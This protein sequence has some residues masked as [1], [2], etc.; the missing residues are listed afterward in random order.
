MASTSSARKS[1]F[2]Y[3]TISTYTD[4]MSSRKVSVR[5]RLSLRALIQIV[6]IGL[7]IYLVLAGLG[8]LAKSISIMRSAT[9]PVLLAAIAAVV[10]SYVFAAVTLL[11]L[12]S[13]RIRFIPTFW[14]VLSGGL[15]N[16]LLPGGLGGLG[17]NALYLKKQ[18]HSLAT[19]TVIVATNNILGF[20]GNSILVALV[21][22]YI[23][24]SFKFS[25]IPLQ[26]WMLI[27]IGIVLVIGIAALYRWEKMAVMS[28]I[29]QTVAY[30]KLMAGHPLRSIGALCSSMA[31]TSCHA[32][33]LYL[34][35]LALHVPASWPMA[36]LA[37]SAGSLVGGLVPTPGGLGGAEAGIAAV[38][39]ALGVPAAAATAAAVVYRGLTYWLPLLPG[40][41]ALQVA[42]KR[43]L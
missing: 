8:G 10:C 28:L 19:A 35:L 5:Q 36:L 25:H 23:P 30:V 2:Q 26:P 43:Y 40:Y 33:G 39:V 12:A 20:I 41:A 18:G 1:L 6:I 24:F 3:I 21:L 13:K 15:V 38:L 22:V 37:V 42:E 7:V 14:V 16:R 17:I 29:R 34:V 31:L 32:T 27:M 4:S 9:L 11:L